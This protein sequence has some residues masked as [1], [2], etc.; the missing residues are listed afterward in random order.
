MTEERKSQEDINELYRVLS[1][2][3][4]EFQEYLDILETLPQESLFPPISVES[5]NTTVPSGEF[6]NARVE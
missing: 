3:C 6:E 1:E 2:E 4:R 5:G